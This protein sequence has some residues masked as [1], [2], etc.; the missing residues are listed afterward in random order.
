MIFHKMA[1]VIKSAAARII[2]FHSHSLLLSPFLT[3]RHAHA[4]TH[5]HTHTH[6]YTH[7]HCPF[8]CDAHACAHLIH[9]WLISYFL[10]THAHTHKHSQTHIHTF[11]S[12]VLLIMA[13][14]KL[15]AA[16]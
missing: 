1:L 15:S 13:E 4:H 2:F 9:Q 11:L 8:Y 6:T 14:W 10:H 12:G 16:E 5:T 7:T 3:D